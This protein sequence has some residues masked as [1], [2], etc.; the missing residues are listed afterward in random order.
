MFHNV[1]IADTGLKRIFKGR[2][3]DRVKDLAV[4]S[5]S[6]ALLNFGIVDLK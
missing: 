5:A 2:T 6:A 4:G 3:V 1:S